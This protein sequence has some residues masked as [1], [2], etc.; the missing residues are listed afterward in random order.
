[1]GLFK[2]R[3]F[4]NLFKA[5]VTLVATGINP[6]LGALVA[7]G[8][9][10]VIN[11]KSSFS[12]D[13]SVY[14]QNKVTSFTERLFQ[15][16]ILDAT[17]IF[18]KTTTGTLQQ[19]T[20]GFKIRLLNLFLKEL[21]I[22]K[23]YFDYHASFV[24]GDDKKIYE[25]Q[26]EIVDYFLQKMTSGYIELV[27]S[28]LN[29]PNDPFPLET[30]RVQITASD[31]PKIGVQFPLN[32][33]GNTVL[34]TYVA[35]APTGTLPITDGEIVG[36]SPIDLPEDILIDDPIPVDLPDVI[37]DVPDLDLPPID[38]DGEVVVVT[39][40]DTDTQDDSGVVV[41]GSGSGSDIPVNDL[42]DSPTVEPSKSQFPWIVVAG[43][44]VSYWFI[45]KMGKK[46]R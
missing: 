36:D 1:M 16:Y 20:H 37:P 27:R 34:A 32:W 26:S 6:V 22:L 44:L 9:E 29:N 25:Y 21:A 8:L 14:V 15:P 13:D 3:W 19:L 23:V 11:E 10:V 18:S 5:V 43:G 46:K 17:D 4:R 7:A 33:K 38:D 12:E 45:S 24:K 28:K 35:F 2:K 40:T 42:I 31:T 41:G 30:Y 39:D